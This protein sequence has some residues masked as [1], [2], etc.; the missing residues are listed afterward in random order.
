MEGPIVQKDSPSDC[1]V[2]LYRTL[3]MALADLGS[4]GD[5][6][7]I[8]VELTRLLSAQF[9]FRCAD[10]PANAALM[11]DIESALADLLASEE[12]AAVSTFERAGILAI[13]LVASLEDKWTLA[14]RDDWLLRRAEG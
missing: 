10:L 4:D 2:T 13:S 9:T 3:R 5:A 7:R 1:V 8:A 6:D 12:I 11:H 14:L